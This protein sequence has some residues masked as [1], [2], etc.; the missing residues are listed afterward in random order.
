MKKM[1]LP[2]SAFFRRTA[3]LFVL[4]Y[5][6]LTSVNA[7]QPGSSPARPLLA[8]RG[9]ITNDK[10]EP[11]A[12][13]S[14]KLKKGNR[15]TSTDSSGHFA[16]M[17]RP[18]YDLIISYI[19]FTQR[20]YIISDP[21]RDINIFLKALPGSNLNDVIVVGYGTQKKANV[22]GAVSVVKAEDLV[23]TKN[24]NVVNMLTGKVPGMR[25]Q[26]MSSEPGSFNTQYDIRG[27]GSSAT[28][29]PSPPLIIIDGVPRGSGDLSRMD[30]S[31]IDNISVLKDASAAIYG[32]K[33]ANGVIL[34]TTK[35]GGRNANGKFNINYSF[36][37]SFQQFLDVPQTVNGAQYME[38][39]NESIKRNFA[40][41]SI[42]TAPPSFSDSLIQQYATG[43]LPSTNWMKAINRT[44]APES[45]HNLSMSGGSDK[46]NYFFDLGYLT[47]GSLFRTNSINYDRWNFR[48]NVNVNFTRRLRGAALVSG[49]TDTKNAPN[50]A[51]WTIFKYA[52]NLLPTDPTY[53]NNNPKSPPLDPVNPNPTP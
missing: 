11:L 53:P 5:L 37:Q 42:T 7:Q 1:L 8:I 34:V 13:A 10:G 39:Y 32:V 44:F 35:R 12:G 15:G 38:L 46:V 18:G 20:K 45:Q 29:N 3:G 33:A 9:R 14:I 27:Y 24:E 31:E 52:E 51:V 49:Y 47:Q 48:S 6:S 22:L 25:I 36:S 4:L 26:Q 41:N 28:G 21:P 19:G 17:A 2:A 43:K 23:V 16:L 50:S 40:T 30:P